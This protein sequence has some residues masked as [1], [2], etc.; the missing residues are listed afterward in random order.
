MQHLF[1]PLAA[2]F[3]VAVAQHGGRGGRGDFGGRAGQWSSCPYEDLQTAKTRARPDGTTMGML[4]NNFEGDECTAACAESFLPFYR[5]CESLAGVSSLASFEQSCRGAVSTL[6]HYGNDRDNTDDC[7][8]TAALPVMMQCA[9]WTQQA[10]VDGQITADDRFCSSDCFQAVTALQSKCEGRIS[11]TIEASMARLETM[12]GRCA[13]T[14]T[15]ARPTTPTTHP[16]DLSAI[17]TACGP[18]AVDAADTTICSDMCNQA[19]REQGRLCRGFPAFQRYI[20]LLERCHDQDE[21]NACAASSDT[22]ISFISKSCC[23][24]ASDCST[25]PD[26]CTPECANTFMPYFSRCGRTVFGGDRNMLQSMEH[27]NR[28]CAM[29][30]GRGNIVVDSGFGRPAHPSTSDG[31]AQLDGPDPS[32]PCSQTESCEECTGTCGW[33][34]EEITSHHALRATHGGWCS[35]ECVTTDGE[36]AIGRQTIGGSGWG[37]HGG[38]RDGNGGGIR[39]GG[40]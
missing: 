12:V 32:D 21:H 23:E 6:N 29:A 36:C 35:S 24:D 9:Q 17:T 31:T 28:M 40:H 8:T 14:L 18:A 38:G 30:A 26:S 3:G 10:L 22:F 5:R 11:R 1:I 19:I 4:C 25:L 33:C 15:P 20:P 27:F 34:R 7:S 16:C 39:G 37:G 2:V 13:A